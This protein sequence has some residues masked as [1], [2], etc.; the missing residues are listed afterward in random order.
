MPE[1]DDSE[2]IT[3]ADFRASPGVDDWRVTFAGPQTH[4]PCPDLATGLRLVEAAVDASAET[5]VAPDIDLRPEGVSVVIRHDIEV[6]MTR[7]GVELAQ[8]ISRSAAGLG[9]TADISRIQSMQLAIA[10]GADVDVQD[11]WVTALG[12]RLVMDGEAIDPLRRN[13]PLWFHRLESGVNGRG[14]THIDVSIPAGLAHDRV[15]AALAAGG[16]LAPS[17][18]VPAWWSL[19]SPDNHGVDIAAWPDGG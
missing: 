16:R 14:R 11:F 13:P 1:D 2:H 19:A 3:S 5:G 10:Q 6:K 4:Y 12:Y 17:S 9:L 15:D 18:N 7:A 8:R